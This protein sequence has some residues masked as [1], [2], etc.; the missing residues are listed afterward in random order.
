MGIFP[1]CFN[2]HRLTVD[3]IY[4]ICIGSR[5]KEMKFIQSTERGFNFIDIETKKKLFK[6]HLYSLEI[7]S[8]K[9]GTYT[10]WIPKYIV[11]NKK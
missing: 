4:F 5:I 8:G 6:K 2:R 1:A 11:I 7:V 3:E 9:G 10:F